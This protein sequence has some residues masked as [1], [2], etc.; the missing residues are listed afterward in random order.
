MRDVSAPKSAGNPFVPEEET[1]ELRTFLF[2]LPLELLG[3]G[4]LFVDSFYRGILLGVVNQHLSFLHPIE[5]QLRAKALVLI[6]LLQGSA[7]F[8]CGGFGF[9]RQKFFQFLHGS[10]SFFEL[11]F[12]GKKVRACF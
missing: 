8:G 9:R 6:H 5:I 7:K 11:G 1:G 4:D 12:R 10:F 2:H 3:F